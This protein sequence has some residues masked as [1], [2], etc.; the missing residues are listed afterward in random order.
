[1]RFVPTT[2]QA[3]VAAGCVAAAVLWVATQ[4]SSTGDGFYPHRRLDMSFHMSAIGER[5]VKP[6]YDMT[7]LQ[8][9]S[10]PCRPETDGYFGSTSGTPLEIQFGFELETED[11]D[12]VEFLLEEIQEQ[13]VDV[14][15]STTFPNLCGFRRRERERHLSMRGLSSQESQLKAKPRTTG[16]KFHMDLD[17]RSEICAPMA[18]PTNLCGVYKNTIGIYGRHLTGV[19]EHLLSQIKDTLN[20]ERERLSKDGL[21]RL[22]TLDSLTMQTNDYGPQPSGIDALSFAAKAGIVVVIIA[23][24]AGFAT[25]FV[26]VY[27][28]RQKERRD[29]TYGPQ[30]KNIT[31][32]GT[33][34]CEEEASHISE[35]VGLRDG[36][37]VILEGGRPVIIEFEK[38]SRGSKSSRSKDAIEEE[39]SECNSTLYSHESADGRSASSQYVPQS[40]RQQQQQLRSVSSAVIEEEKEPEDSE[41]VDGTNTL[42]H[43]SASV[44]PAAPMM[45]QSVA[46]FTEY[47]E[48]TATDNDR[49]GEFT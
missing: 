36:T 17:N 28:E 35:T 45:G 20:G 33:V 4:S 49:A 46:S 2:K 14:V 34:G 8:Y 29:A 24:V 26:Y 1:M 25:F 13:V 12:P 16:F 43:A 9:M 10:S 5:N 48:Q 7:Q 23:L 39:R 42:Q 44:K 37:A 41:T 22:T 19:G 21:V 32:N 18:D 11:E 3:W 15:L 47:T 27:L 30:G 40:P 6:M 38:G 31:S